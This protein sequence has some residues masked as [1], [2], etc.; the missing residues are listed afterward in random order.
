MDA[1]RAR[2]RIANQ[3]AARL[4]KPM[5]LGVVFELDLP[6]GKTELLTWLYRKNGDVGGAYFAE[7]EAL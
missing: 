2:I 4:V 1:V 6:V 7:V 5:S 3:E